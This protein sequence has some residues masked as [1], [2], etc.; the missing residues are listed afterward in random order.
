MGKETKIRFTITSRRVRLDPKK[1]RQGYVD[2]LDAQV[3]SLKAMIKTQNFP[4]KMK[5]RAMEVL[6]K[7]INSS[8]D[9]VSDIE[10]EILEDEL[11]T[12]KEED[13]GIERKDDLGY[14]IEEDPSL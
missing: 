12:I 5:L 2:T 4:Q 11:K 13:Q 9:I 14:T 3:E 7:T 10:V 6:I 8:N 1:K